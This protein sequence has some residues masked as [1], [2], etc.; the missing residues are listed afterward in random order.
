MKS[1][2]V[3]GIMPLTDPREKNGFGLPVV[4]LVVD[5]AA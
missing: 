4:G 3:A 1:V 5:L 2:L